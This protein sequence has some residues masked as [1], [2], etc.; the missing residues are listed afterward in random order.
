MGRLALSVLLAV[1]P[2]WAAA[3]PLDLDVEIHWSSKHWTGSDP[4]K[5]NEEN[6][7][8]GLTVSDYR[9]GP[10]FGF[11]RYENSYF[12]PATTAFV[13]DTFAEYN[14][15]DLHATIGGEIH[16]VHGY[17]DH[18]VYPVVP[19]PVFTLGTDALKIKMRGL[20][21]VLVG[22]SAVWAIQ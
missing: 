1:V 5:Y 10:Y 7:G 9:G 18:L 20:P 21:G 19:M 17:D 16:V 3:G 12:E 8:F 4:N 13:G 15:L 14:L 2:L 11:L 22:F 6:R